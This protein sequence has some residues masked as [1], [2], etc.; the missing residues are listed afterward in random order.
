[1]AEVTHGA[2]PDALRALAEEMLTHAE[3]TLGVGLRTQLQLA[4]L[5][6]SG[7]DAER[8]RQHWETV[9]LPRIRETS[10][11]LA[12]AAGHVLEQA[13]EQ[14][15]ASEATGS[16]TAPSAP[17]GA[18]PSGT[19][20]RTAPETGA[21]LADRARMLLD[22][23][24]NGPELAQ[25]ASMV[26][27]GGRGA[28]QMTRAQYDLASALVGAVRP[29]V[30]AVVRTAGTLGT[31]VNVYDAGMGLYR[32]DPVQATSGIGG[33]AA[34][35]AGGPAVGAA[36]GGGWFLGS[37]AYEGMQGTS[38]GDAVERRN[39]AAFETMGAWGMLIVPGNLALGAWDTLTEPD[40]PKAGGG[41]R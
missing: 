14:E 5:R 39:D 37:R 31:A 21:S 17:T 19:G 22:V 33:I 6:W 10:Q 25:V 32:G 23:L 12:E 2:D 11:S 28:L 4:E 3:F 35:A 15:V 16:V 41:G 8:A 26:A 40:T 30:G 7:P 36:W 34:T 13:R 27:M 9:E 20:V 1:M 18:P 38:Y 24:V 29:G